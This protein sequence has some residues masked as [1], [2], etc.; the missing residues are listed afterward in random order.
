MSQQH[1]GILGVTQGKV[2]PIVTRRWKKMN[3]QQGYNPYVS[4]PRTPAQQLHRAKFAFIGHL[5]GTMLPVLKVGYRAVAEQKGTT[6]I[7]CFVK[8][9]WG[10]LVGSRPDTVKINPEEMIVAD[11]RVVPV[12]F[13]RPDMEAERKVR[14]TWSPMGGDSW[15]SV[16]VAV[17]C[18]EIDESFLSNA[19]KRYEQLLVMQLP[20]HFKDKEIFMYGF[21][22]G[23]ENTM[24][25]GEASV[26]S[27]IWNDVVLP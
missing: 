27:F 3:I 9:N 21:V 17:Y 16:F 22:I 24:F 15:D 19:A 20:V 10:F 18:P 2:G 7:G 11:G 23:S 8:C 14:F 1:Y 6:E 12:E 4:N 13:V 5:A 25:G 26:S